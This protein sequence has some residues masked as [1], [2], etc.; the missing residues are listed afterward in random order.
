MRR[1]SRRC[2]GASGSSY[3]LVHRPPIAGENVSKATHLGLP[4]FRAI[5]DIWSLAVAVAECLNTENALPRK[6]LHMYTRPISYMPTAIQSKYLRTTSTS[7]PYCIA[8]PPRKMPP[9]LFPIPIPRAKT[10]ER[11]H[12]RKKLEIGAGAGIE[13]MDCF[14]SPCMC[15]RFQQIPPRSMAW[16][17]GELSDAA[18]RVYSSEFRAKTPCRIE[19]RLASA[20]LMTRRSMCARISVTH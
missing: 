2:L 13:R 4:R 1:H 12:F 9:F 7:P 18:E 10:P 20:F 19:L 11:H 16:R 17:T 15:I 6:P 3:S 14:H 8:Y 5:Q